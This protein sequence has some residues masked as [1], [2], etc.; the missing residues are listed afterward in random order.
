[1][2]TFCRMTLVARQ[3][4]GKREGNIPPIILV[5]ELYP[6]PVGESNCGA[7]ANGGDGSDSP[8]WGEEEDV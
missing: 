4:G 6:E 5:A 2:D 1:M 3:D 7:K 8:G